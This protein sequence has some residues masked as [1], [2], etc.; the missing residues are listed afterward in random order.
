M[1]QRKKKEPFQLSPAATLLWAL[2][3]AS[4]CLV[5]TSNSLGIVIVNNLVTPVDRGVRHL[6]RFRKI[7]CRP[8]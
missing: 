5:S 4:F 2:M 8:Q 7:V 1:N 3:A 6:F